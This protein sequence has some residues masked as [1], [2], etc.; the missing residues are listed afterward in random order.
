MPLPQCGEHVCLYILQGDVKSLASEFLL[1]DFGDVLPIQ[2]NFRTWLNFRLSF[3]CHIFQIGSRFAV[4]QLLLRLALTYT[5]NQV[6]WK[7]KSTEILKVGNKGDINRAICWQLFD[8]CPG[9]LFVC[10]FPNA[11]VGLW[12]SQRQIFGSKLLS[13]N[14]NYNNK[15]EFSLAY[16][17]F[18]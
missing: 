4:L 8:F 17:F 7:C 6:A 18:E 5:A 14:N 13:F 11:T 2:L 1:E 10:F 3:F 12:N 16:W 9:F 15:K